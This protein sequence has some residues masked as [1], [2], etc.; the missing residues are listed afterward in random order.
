M[1]VI[2]NSG[3]YMGCLEIGNCGAGEKRSL[4]ISKKLVSK[5]LQFF[6]L[7]W[8]FTVC[9]ACLGG[10][11]KCARQYSSKRSAVYVWIWGQLFDRWY[12]HTVLTGFP[13]AGNVRHVWWWG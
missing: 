3:D 2:T 10:W 5:A 12:N 8:K 1:W 7:R 11:S 9:L 13:D 4:I 6:G